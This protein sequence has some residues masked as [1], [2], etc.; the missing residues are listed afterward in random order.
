MV[1]AGFYLLS[2][3]ENVPKR[4]EQYA[5]LQIQLEVG[6]KIE[7]INIWQDEEMYYFFLPSTAKLN[8]ITFCN[9]YSQDTIWLNGE[10]KFSNIETDVVYELQCM[11]D[12]ITLEK[13]PLQ[14][15]QS[16]NI[17][18]MFV[19]TQSKTTDAIH[20]SKEAEEPANVVLINEKGKVDYNSEI[21]YIRTRGNSTFLNFEKKAYQLK[22]NERASFL[23]MP[24][25]KKWILL[26]N[27]IDDSFIRNALVYEF[28]QEYTAVPSIEGTFVDLYMNGTYCGNYYL[29]EKVEVDKYRVQITDLDSK[30]ETEN[31]KQVVEAAETIEVEDGKYRA[32]QG[33][34]NPDDIT[35][36]YL[37][38]SITEEEYASVTSGFRTNGGYYFKITSP[39]NATIEQAKYI[40]SLFD[41]FE[42]AIE[43][44][45][46]IHPKTGKH[47]TDYIDLDSWIEKYLID[48]VF[49]DPDSQVA[50]L[51]FYKDA[52]SIDTHIF[53]GP[54]WDYDRAIG[55]YG[56]NSYELDDPMKIGIYGIYVPK[57]IKK[58]PEAKE[59]LQDKL[60]HIF[61]PYIE[62][63]LNADVSKYEALLT[64]SIHCDNI[65]W[66]QNYDYYAAF[67]SS[68]DYIK[69]FMQQKKNALEELWLKEE[70][71]HTVS[72]L[73]YDGN[74]IQTYRVK[75]GEY[76][77][78]Q[79]ATPRCYVA[80]FTG[81]T[82][83]FTGKAYDARLP[84]LENSIYQ[85]EWLSLDLL[86]QN[87]LNMAEMDVL[88]V[89]VDA[90]E[91]LLRFIK[92]KQKEQAE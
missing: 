26:A 47:Y 90:M 48:E 3:P 87:G 79:I 45:D 54:V 30:N 8:S 52:D 61:I 28:A 25:G 77:S 55:S 36:G 69:S 19:E 49:H 7:R 23:G 4:A 72:F 16:A 24:K 37:L 15:V 80:V 5:D 2:T 73:D 62:E 39:Q 43:T 17:A 27:A 76:L 22:L 20:A 12:G 71:Y 53:A 64:A 66:P 83:V 56:A 6:E 9:V 92:E 32:C 70:V 21:E 34:N 1:L 35:G 46:G 51:F 50:S 75:H 59:L 14:F 31:G 58:Y 38:E 68:M 81:W 65:R 91:D 33:L 85:S 67:E 10:E 40:C 86:M 42:T 60:K 84:I 41:E 74:L 82:N 63:Q 78:Q 11:F 88:Q 57:I 18:V 89:D 13:V 44:K 29:C